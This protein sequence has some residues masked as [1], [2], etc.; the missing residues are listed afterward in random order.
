MLANLT[1]RV[2]AGVAWGT[3]QAVLGSKLTPEAGFCLGVSHSCYEAGTWACRTPN[4]CFSASGIVPNQPHSSSG[5]VAGAE[6]AQ[7]E[8]NKVVNVAASAADDDYDAD[9]NDDD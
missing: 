3:A 5:N 1:A 2:A 6:A 7:P 9:G 8:T 4:A